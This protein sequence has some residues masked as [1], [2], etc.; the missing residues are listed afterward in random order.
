MRGG[1]GGGGGGGCGGD[2]G[3]GM[4]PGKRALSKRMMEASREAHS[5]SDAL[6]NARMAA[7]L[8]DRRKWG[9][10]LASF[11][12]VIREVEALVSRHAGDEPALAAVCRMLPAAGR[13]AAMEEDLAFYLG[14]EWEDA[15]PLR[16]PGVEEYLAHLRGLD[17]L[18]LLPYAYHLHMGFCSGGRI[19]ARTARRAMSLPDGCGTKSFEGFGERGP[20]ALKR[21]YKLTVDSLSLEEEQVARILQESVKVFTVSATPSRTE[22]RPSPPPFLERLAAGENLGL[23][24]EPP[25]KLNN[26]LIR[27]MAFS[28]QVGDFWRLLPDTYRWAISLFGAGAILFG[29]TLF[30]RS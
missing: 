30:G 6:V 19:L 1:G 24:R 11:Y 26:A 5:A 10:A 25:P 20:A 23:T 8:A 2:W 4:E 18:L 13:T 15:L 22:P 29:A 28:A 9:L 14:R 12:V 27:G 16:S 7:A 3:G 17:P 21:E